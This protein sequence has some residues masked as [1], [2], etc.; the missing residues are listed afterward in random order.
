MT[1]GESLYMCPTC[2]EVSQTRIE[3]HGHTM[4]RFE[5]AAPATRF[6]SH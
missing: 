6:A 2:F 5:R 1:N 4:V 3:C